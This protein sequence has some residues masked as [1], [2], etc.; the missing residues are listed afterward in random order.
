MTRQ[1][2]LVLLA[3]VLGFLGTNAWADGM[4]VRH[5]DLRPCGTGPFAGA[6]IGAAVGF[7]RQRDEINDVLPLSPTFGAKFHD[8]DSSV[9]FGGYTGYNWQCDRF[10]FGVETDFDYLNTSPTVFV[11]TSTLEGRMDWFGT[12]RARA[13]YA[14]HEDLLLYVTGGLAYANVDHTF[15]STC[16]M[17]S[18]GSKNIAE[19][20]GTLIFDI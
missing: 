11:D 12:L 19:I 10:V 6:Y 16:S 13:G 8:S 17:Q 15:S 4:P 7:G 2:Q 20:F 1:L 18:I 3:L 9:T 14:V 5:S